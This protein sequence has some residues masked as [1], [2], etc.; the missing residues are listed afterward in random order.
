[1]PGKA[2][3]QVNPHTGWLTGDIEPID[4]PGADRSPDRAPLD[5][6]G[7]AGAPPHQS[8]FRPITVDVYP[9]GYSKEG[10]MGAENLLTQARRSA[11]MSQDE[12]ARRAHTSRP[13]LSAYEH[14]H[15]SPTLE[16][17]ARVLAEAGF[18]L[19][20]Q[21]QVQF[22]E[23]ITARGRVVSVPTSASPAADRAS[24]GHGCLT[25]ALELVGTRP[26]VLHA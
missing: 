10:F 9:F 24:L 14:G 20:I 26:T 12:L 3:L 16:T 21:P 7:A 5:H 17:A 19:T 23:Q 22:A 11:G 1:M 8:R 6:D 2:L 13:T 25:A 18:V 15:K 4:A